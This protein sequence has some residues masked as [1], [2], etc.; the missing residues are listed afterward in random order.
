MNLHSNQQLFRDAVEAT[1]Q[2]INIP[3]IYI[4]KDYWVTVALHAIFHS[5]IGD[6]VVFKGGTALS[7]CHKL[8]ERFS[9]DVDIVVL[10]SPGES[11]NQ[12]KNK[13]KEVTK[14]VSTVIP[15]IEIDEITNKMGQIR[16]TAHKYNRENFKS[17]FGQIREYIIIEASWL[18]SYEP[19]IEAPVNSYISEMMSATGTNDII[20]KYQLQPFTVKVLSKERTLCEK[21]MSLVT[22]SQTEYPYTDLANKIRHIYDIH[23]MLENV[24]VKTFFDSREFNT[25]LLKVGNDDVLSYKNKNEWLKNHPAEA[26]IFSQ[27]EATWDKIKNTY[28][29]LFK[30]MVIG[31]LPEEEALVA[32]LISIEKR[33][34]KVTWKI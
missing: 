16:K 26:I 22:F 23:M 34:L 20:S 31:K 8:I 5:L 25:L 7:K 19:F 1:S 15:E 33:L 17:E 21:I 10:S 11:G 27:P 18:G 29:T 13:I 2:R 30:N 14:A 24:D 32:T 12:L 9:E 6:Q 28:R 3:E 4:E